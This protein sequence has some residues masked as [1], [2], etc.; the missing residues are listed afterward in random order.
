MPRIIYSFLYFLLLPFILLNYLLR[1]FR[2]PNYRSHSLER[3]SFNLP[4]FGDSRPIHFHL[5]SVGEANAA[6]DLV[7]RISEEFDKQKILI[8]V[9]TPT[10]RMRCFELFSSQPNIEICYLPFDIPIFTTRFFNSVQP[11]CSVLMETEVWPNFMHV[12]EQKKVPVALM[13]ARMSKSSFRGYMRFRGIS[14]S[15]FRS[16]SL[17]LAQYSADMKRLIKL[18][19]KANICHTIGNVKFDSKIPPAILEY[20]IKIKNEIGRPTW[21]AISTHEGEE[22][23]AI[24][25]HKIILERI[26]NALLVLVPRHQ[27]RF[28]KVRELLERQKV[29]YAKRS[30]GTMISASTQVFLGNS[31]GEMFL[32]IGLA[33]CAFVGG[34]L[35][36]IGGHNPIEPATN[37]LPVITGPHIFNFSSIY[38]QS[39]EQGFCSYVSN[40]DE[41]ASTILELLT[42]PTLLEARGLKAKRFV[43]KNEGSLEACVTHMTSFISEHV[44]RVKQQT[45][46]K[47]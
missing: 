24:D 11:C 41:L 33:D 45:C 15:M 16:L 32:Y 1:S 23:A 8:S 22:K 5:V 3:L 10:G 7:K 35:V 2:D 36:K 44:Q 21:I 38:K 29:K 42:N 12:A 43:E 37:A 30:E 14:N 18:G 17:V 46:D 27:E 26:P 20:G 31:M 25:A 6:A 40:S 39:Y 19:C 4:S 47:V 34:S 9:T 13:N 28:S